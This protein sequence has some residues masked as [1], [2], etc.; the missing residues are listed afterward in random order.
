IFVSMGLAAGAF[1]GLIG[2]FVVEQVDPRVR[3]PK[4]LPNIL[5]VRTLGVIPTGPA[6]SN[7]RRKSAKN[8]PGSASN[9]HAGIEFVTIQD[10]PSPMAESFR[11]TLA[12]LMMEDQTGY[13]P[14]VILV[15][16]AVPREGKTVISCNL[17][18][19][20]AEAGQKVLLI[21]GDLRRPRLGKIFCCD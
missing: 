8:N 17:A 4:Q 18:L 9:G 12:S 20:M 13:R 7:G 14:K 11:A 10:S 21:D 2:A 15:T 16:S 5:R 1:L 3:M 6:R 19:A